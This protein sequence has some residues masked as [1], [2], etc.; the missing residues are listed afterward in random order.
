MIAERFNG[1]EWPTYRYY[2]YPFS[3][4]GPKRVELR[5]YYDKECP[6]YTLGWY[7][8]VKSAQNDRVMHIKLGGLYR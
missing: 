7:G 8:D 2:V 6:G 3:D 4:K 5:A 1:P